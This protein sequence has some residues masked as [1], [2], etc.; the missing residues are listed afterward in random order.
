[1]SVKGKQ[2]VDG[3]LLEYGEE[4]FYG[5]VKSKKSTSSDDLLAGVARGLRNPKRLGK[6][7][8][9]GNSESVTAAGIR[10]KLAATASGKLPEVMVKITGSGRNIKQ[11]KHHLDYVSRNGKVTLEDQDGE[12]IRGRE[13][14]QDLRDE[15][16]YGGFG[17]PEDGTKAR[18]SFNVVLSMPPGTDPLAVTRAA[19]DFA[20]DQFGGSND[21]VFGTHDDDKHPH[22]HLVIRARDYGGKRLNPRKEDLQRWRRVFADKLN[23]H[24]IEANATMRPSRGVNRKP[25]KRTVLEAKKRG[26]VLPNYRDPNLTDMPGSPA[27]EA[28]ARTFL[29][30]REGYL[31]I[32]EALEA[33]PEP[34]DRKLAADIS[35]FLKDMPAERRTQQLAEHGR[36]A[37]LVDVRSEKTPATS[38]RTQGPT[39]RPGR[40][41]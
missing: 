24:G 18:E 32:S 1:M 41:K 25:I 20:R 38:K 27:F 7:N 13:A 5:K 4:L 2:V 34:A 8:Q 35:A 12:E 10:K 23:E 19:R 40:D 22:V 36:R 14:V 28:S 6:L 9:S 21:Y 30:V 17:I 37:R 3:V 39:K 16:Q 31:K 33:S 26:R 29:K 11:I 15:W